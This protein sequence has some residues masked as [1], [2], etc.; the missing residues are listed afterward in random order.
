MVGLNA[1]IGTTISSYS[2][3]ASTVSAPPLLSRW[4]G[5]RVEKS[6]LI[7]PDGESEQW[8]SAIAQR[9]VC[10]WDYPYGRIFAGCCIREYRARRVTQTGAQ[11]AAEH[12]EAL[13]A[14]FQK[15]ASADAINGIT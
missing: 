8:V 15:A 3:S 14:L 6:L 11:P 2:I 1:Y 12:R 7:G 5:E 13:D 10:C 4:I 9:I